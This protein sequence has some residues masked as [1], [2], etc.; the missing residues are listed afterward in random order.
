MPLP[1]ASCAFF[2]SSAGTSTVIFLAAFMVNLYPI[3]YTSPLYGEDARANSG[4]ILSEPCFYPKDPAPVL[5][6]FRNSP[7]EPALSL[8]NGGD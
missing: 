6:L 2:R 8:S 7:G 3:A 1:L 5:K 4:S